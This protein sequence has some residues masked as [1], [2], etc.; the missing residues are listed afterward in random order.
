ML[1]IAPH[2]WFSWDFTISQGSQAVADIGFTWWREQGELRLDGATYRV[3]R[4]HLLNG[5]FLLES[6]AGVIARA[7]RASLFR[8]RFSV[9]HGANTYTLEP[10]SA[11][12]RAF[13]LLEDD[14]ETGSIS[15]SRA[16]SRRASANL[17]SELPLPVQVFLIWLTVLMWKRESE[18]ASS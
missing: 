18:S 5:D 9:R 3:S 10:R 17:P 1:Q 11:F 12:Q 15:P 6:D 14:R 4:E 8:R 7:T 13:V 2:G 16:W